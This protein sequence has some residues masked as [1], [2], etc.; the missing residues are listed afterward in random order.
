MLN[1]EKISLEHLTQLSTLPVTCSL[2][3]LG[4]PKKSFFNMI[5]HILQIIYIIRRKQIASVALQFKLFTYCC[6]MLPI[7]CIALV[8]CLEH[9]YRGAHVLIWIC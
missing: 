2:F 6:L 1:P 9:K 8:L 5:I 4:N 3:T 7:I